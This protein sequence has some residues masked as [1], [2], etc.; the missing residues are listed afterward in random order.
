MPS[1]DSPSFRLNNS[2]MSIATTAEGLKDLTEA[3]NVLTTGVRDPAVEKQA[4]EDM[5]RMREE[6]RKRVGTVEVAVDLIREARNP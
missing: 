2:V 3:V 4:C 1:V 5:D 6:T